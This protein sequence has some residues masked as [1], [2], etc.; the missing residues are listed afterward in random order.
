MS[1]TSE[2]MSAPFWRVAPAIW[3]RLGECADFAPI[4]PL[5]VIGPVAELCQDSLM[6]AR[7]LPVNVYMST[8][9]FVVQVSDSLKRAHELML[10]HGVSCLAVVEGDRQL[11]G[12]VSRTD[13]LR[14]GTA[15]ERSRWS[16]ALILPDQ[17]VHTVMSP[18]V[19]SVAIDSSVQEAAA[20]MVERDVQRVFVTARADVAG[21]F[22]TQDAMRALVDLAPEAVGTRPLSDFMSS[23]VKTIGSH[24]GLGEATRALDDSDVHGLVVIERGRPVGL[25]AMADA[26]EARRWPPEHPLDELMNLR[27]LSLPADTQ[28]RRAAQQAAATRVRRVLVLDSDQLTGILTGIDFA[29]ALA[30]TRA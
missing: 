4:A 23:P 11:R 6:S 26:L 21:V 16:R 10:T 17:Q 14:I 30:E 25:F 7:E 28:M 12:I 18:D 24:V 22:S 20:M 29:R 3:A 27:I 9:T 5:S 15:K 2:Q 13:L 8:P 19:I 1:Q